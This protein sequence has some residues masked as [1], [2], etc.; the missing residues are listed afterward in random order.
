[1]N[2]KSKSN[3]KFQWLSLAGLLSA[4]GKG[5]AETATVDV[6]KTLNN[7]EPVAVIL[8]AFQGPTT[9]GPLVLQ[10]FYGEFLNDHKEV[11]VI[12]ED[13]DVDKTPDPMLRAYQDF[14]PDVI[15]VS[16]GSVRNTDY[17][18][19]DNYN[20]YTHDDAYLQSNQTLWENGVT[21][22][23]A[24][25]ND[26]LN[27]AAVATWA[28]SIFPIVVG[29]YSQYDGDIYDWSNKGSAVVHYYEIGDG[30][31]IEGTSFSAPRVAAQVALIKSEH[32]TI[33]ESSVRTILEKNSVYDF[34]SGDYVQKIDEITNTDPSIDTRVKVEAVF[35]IFEGRNPSQTELDNWINLVDSGEETLGTMARWFAMNGVQTQDVP[36]IER[37]QAFY[38][39]WLGRESQDSEIVAMFN[40][41][42]QTQSWDQTFDNFLELEHVDTSYS[43]VYNNYDVLATEV[44]A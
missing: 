10:N 36:P 31:G 25:G 8:D 39:Y 2:K 27:D 43:F 5:K 17:P 14:N 12:A 7:S 23:A 24:A 16:W 34:D 37:M 40:D 28:S 11:T 20:T 9:H 22:T 42:V 18:H 13:V 32:N 41:L 30:W 19:I 44:M 3:K 1:M 6:P 15:N 29:A 21:V 35:E 26:G 4:C 33:S 38:H